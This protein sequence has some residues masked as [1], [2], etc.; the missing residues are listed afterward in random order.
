MN[1][2]QFQGEY[3]PN[4]LAEVNLGTEKSCVYWKH[5]L[6]HASPEIGFVVLTLNFDCKQYFDTYFFAFQYLQQ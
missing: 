3:K 5:Q 1:H 2:S 4:I 6:D